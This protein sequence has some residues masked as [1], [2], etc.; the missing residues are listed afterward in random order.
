MAK[1]KAAAAVVFDPVQRRAQACHLLEQV[2]KA[3]EFHNAKAGRPVGKS[4]LCVLPLP[5]FSLRYLLQN[6]GLLLYRVY[7]LLGRWGSYKS[8]MYGE[9]VRWHYEAGG[10]GYRLE[11]EDKEADQLTKAVLGHASGALGGET[12]RDVEHWQDQMTEVIKSLIKNYEDGEAEPMP[13]SLGV[14]SIG[15]AISGKALDN[16]LKEG[17]AKKRFADEAKMNSD[18]LRAYKAMVGGW[19]FTLWLVNH[20]KQQTNSVTGMAERA[21]GGGDLIK[22]QTSQ[23]IEMTKLG[24]TEER[25]DDTRAKVLL[26]VYKNSYGIEGRRIQADFLTWSQEEENGAS[27]LYAK[28]DWYGASIKLLRCEGMSTK[29]I[30]VFKPQIDE[31]IDIHEKNAGNLGKL[32]WSTTLG[33]PSGEAMRA[34]DLGRI[35]ETKIEVLEALYAALRIARRPFLPSAVK[36]LA[37]TGRYPWV[38][39][40]AAA[41]QV[42]VAKMADAGEGQLREPS[43]AADEE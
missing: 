8:T 16:I 1:K 43:A 32:Y 39:E 28:F 26:R 20:L 29:Q 36:M 2:V 35:L 42:A 17:H 18:Y 9:S 15:G 5:A 19:P 38:E 24:D 10:F 41:A 25:R 31:I 40:H 34:D 30:T 27:R 37:A 14:D 11:T 6:E 13:V 21:S 7:H 4:E 22:F 33:V 23:E 12:C 3:A